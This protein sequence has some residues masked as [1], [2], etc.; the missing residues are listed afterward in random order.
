LAPGNAPG[1]PGVRVMRSI[2]GSPLQSIIS[3]ADQWKLTQQSEMV[4]WF[5]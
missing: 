1:V 3:E 5:M 4:L 2:I